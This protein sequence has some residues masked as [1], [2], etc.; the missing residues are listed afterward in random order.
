MLTHTLENGVL[1]ISL[2]A[3]V[4]I[5]DRSAL[6]TGI[7]RLVGAY[8]PAPVVVELDTPAVAAAAVSAVVRAHR[9]CARLGVPMCVATSG[10]AAR[11]LIQ[12]NSDTS[13]TPLGVH[14]TTAEAV[15]ALSAGAA[16]SGDGVPG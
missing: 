4:G 12:A 1:V 15:A 5:G 10:A 6:S 16:R 14:A 8:A 11:R 3:D 13:G 7:A 9:M 2:P